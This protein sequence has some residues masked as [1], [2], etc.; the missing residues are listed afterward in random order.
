MMLGTSFIFNQRVS[1]WVF[2]KLLHGNQ[3][4]FWNQIFLATW[5][6]AW[7]TLVWCLDEMDIYTYTESTDYMRVKFG[8]NRHTHIHR[9]Y[10]LYEGDV[11]MKSTY[12]HTHTRTHAHT[13]TESKDYIRVKF[14]WNGHTH[15]HRKYRLY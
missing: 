5:R 12:T 9:K 1:R 14:G 13:H 7:S 4:G 2:K 6:E 11:W 10:R 8:W 15:T 3:T